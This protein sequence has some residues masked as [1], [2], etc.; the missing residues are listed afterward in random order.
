MF[1][2]YVCVYPTNFEEVPTVYFCICLTDTNGKS[3]RYSHEQG[4]LRPCPVEER[5][6]YQEIAT[7]M[8]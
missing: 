7:Q 8:E 5:P 2:V 3:W 1:S 6:S 4:R